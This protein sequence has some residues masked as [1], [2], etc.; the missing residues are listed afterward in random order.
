MIVHPDFFHHFKT[1]KLI[2]L[3]G[4]DVA[5]LWVLKLWAYCQIKRTSRFENLSDAIL[6]DI[7]ECKNSRVPVRQLLLDCG[8]I[9][10]DGNTT[11]VHDWDN[12]NASL[13]ASWRNGMRG[14]WPGAK[15]THGKP[16]GSPRATDGQP[17]PSYLI[18]KSTSTRE[19]YLGSPRASES[20]E[21]PKPENVVE[22]GR[23]CGELVRKLKAGDKLNTE[24]PG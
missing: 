18:N 22:F 14:G 4:N 19:E 7:C 11:I 20:E 21:Q 24:E 10:Q 5:P 2:E 1:R 3:A 15:R 12:V 6:A 8:F 9:V 23:L 16:T 13:L 17:T